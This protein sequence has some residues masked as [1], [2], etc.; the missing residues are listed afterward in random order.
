MTWYWICACSMGVPTP[1]WQPILTLRMWWAVCDRHGPPYARTRL[2]KVGAYGFES[3]R[4]VVVQLSS[5][6]PYLN[7]FAKVS[8][9]ILGEGQA[10]F[11]T[12]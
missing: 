9:R 11:D 2:I 12:R 1:R 10:S 3:A 6:G 5:N 8:Q 4:R 7:H